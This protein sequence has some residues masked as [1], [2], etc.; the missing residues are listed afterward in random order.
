MPIYE[1]QCE[2]CGKVIEE[3]Q[4]FSDPP[5]RKCPHCAGK[6][7]KLISRSGFQLKGDGWYVTDYK[8]KSAPSDSKIPTADSESKKKETK[9]S[10]TGSST[11]VE[12][13]DPKA[14]PGK[15]D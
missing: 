5:L 11:K 4:K 14:G 15:A 10:G 6:L 2:S 9:E 7:N 3:L 13:K 1:Y 8:K 12:K